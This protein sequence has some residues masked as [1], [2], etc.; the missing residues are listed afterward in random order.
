MGPG[1]FIE[2]AANIAGGVVGDIA[3][4]GD[5]N[6]ADDYQQRALLKL[7]GLDP[8]ALAIDPAQVGASGFA[9]IQEDP[10]L[11]SAQ[12]NALQ[13]MQ[14]VV[15]SGGMD[16]QSRDAYAQAQSLTEQ[17]ARGARE[18]LQSQNARRGLGNSGMAMADAMNNQQAAAGRLNAAGSKAAA[19]ARARALAAMQN[20]QAMGSNIRGDD[21]RKSADAAQAADAIAAFNATNRQSADR[22]NSGM[23]IDVTG[24]Q[25]GALQNAS[26]YANARAE[27][28]RQKFG[29][30]AKGVGKMVNGAITS[31]GAE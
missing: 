4:A 6:K 7:L 25:S 23:K 30:A 8:D 16:A 21:Y 27:R 11:R 3:A 31:G 24:M 17:Q 1:D 29:K 28:T 22:Y 9:D 12:M 15:N 20:L 2:G 26:D 18:A 19:D 5:Q 14:D 10:A 13:R